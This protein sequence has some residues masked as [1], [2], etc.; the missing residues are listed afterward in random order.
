MGDAAGYGEGSCFSLKQLAGKGNDLLDLGLQGPAVGKC[1]EELLELVM[2]G[3]L[4][5]DRAMLL[6]Y[7]K[8][9]LL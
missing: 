4:P 6:A 3:E 5:N 8:E 9:K 2:D 1:L 7:T